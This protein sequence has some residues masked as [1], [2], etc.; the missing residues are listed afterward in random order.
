VKL[1][2]NASDTCVMPSDAYGGAVNK[3]S[4]FGWHK[5]FKEEIDERCGR[6]R[7]HRTDENIE[8]LRSLVHLD[9]RSSIIAVTVQL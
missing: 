1:G 5:R 6:P 9:R 7:Y 4:V 8:K 2:K 3:I